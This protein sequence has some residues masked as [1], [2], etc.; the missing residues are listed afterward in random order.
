MKC[1]AMI[2]MVSVA[3]VSQGFAVLRPLVPAKAAP[4]FSGELIV[5]GND[6]IHHPVKHAPAI[7]PR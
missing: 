3:F 2:L 1:A 4:P 6:S 7:V 5:I